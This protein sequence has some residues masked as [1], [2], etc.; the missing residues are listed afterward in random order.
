MTAVRVA[1]TLGPYR[2]LSAGRESRESDQKGIL[3][4]G[5]E[6]LVCE[7]RLRNNP[8]WTALRL[9]ELK[10]TAALGLTV[11]KSKASRKC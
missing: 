1:W 2:L 10:A 11:S 5:M 3:E 7:L 4:H 8:I 6:R 9:Y